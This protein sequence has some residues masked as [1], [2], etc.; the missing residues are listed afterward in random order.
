MIIHFIKNLIFNI[1]KLNKPDGVVNI[2]IESFNQYYP[3]LSDLSVNQHKSYLN[4]KKEW[5]KGLKVEIDDNISYLFLHLHELTRPLNSLNYKSIILEIEL[6]KNRYIEHDNLRFY[7]D[8]TVADIYYCDKNYNKY[9]E[10]KLSSLYKAGTSTQVANDVLN[11]KY[12][13]N[14]DVTARE[15]LSISNKL[16]AYGKDNIDQIEVIMNRVLDEDTDYSID[17]FITPVFD[18]CKESSPNAKI[19]LFCGNPYGYDLNEEL[20]P[21]ES[22]A[23][24][25]YFYADKQFLKAINKLSRDSENIH[26][27]ERNLPKV[28]EG[29]INETRLF[30]LIKEK[31]KEYE[32]VHQYRSGWLGRQSLD[33]FIEDVNIA[34]E[35][36]GAQHYKPVEFFG[37]EEA[38]KKNIERDKRKMSL[39]KSND[40]KLI[41]VN[42]G[43]S[44]D[45]VYSEINK[46]IV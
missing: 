12:Q 39:C 37:G 46:Y 13:L 32:V 40:V 42:E 10:K 14:Q 27:E 38:F 2:H 17:K 31:F 3:R 29:W 6:L 16:T 21:K 8:S 45:N 4:I 11:I 33:I 1:K 19:S 15:L 23:S 7:C 34:I 44:I 35:Y 28:N 43:Y 24:H 20:L 18:R 25:V 26:R 9:L 30:Y 41:Y 22:N 36:Q 5:R